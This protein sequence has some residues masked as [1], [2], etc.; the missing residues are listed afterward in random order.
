M[1]K[2]GTTELT[3]EISQEE[4]DQAK[5]AI[6]SFKQTIKSLRKATEYLNVMHDPFKANPSIS[7]DQVLKYRAAIRRFRDTAIENFNDVK[8]QAFRCISLIQMFTS[9]TQI[10][11]LMKSFISSI[12]LLEKKVNE[13]ASLFVRLKSDTLVQDLLSA[14]ED[15]QKESKS[16]QESIDE[17]IVPYLE[18]NIIGDVWIHSMEDKLNEKIEKKKP[19]I[20]DI[21][22]SG[23]E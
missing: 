21:L 17:R 4:K 2:R 18:S 1:F 13:F 7:T 20:V 22:N 19:A 10:S 3:S 16:L 14:I 11:K 23:K 9:D 8:I 15:I 5:K 6:E 12:E